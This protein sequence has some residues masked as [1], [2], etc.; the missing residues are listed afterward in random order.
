ME[1][2]AVRGHAR[3]AVDDV[4]EANPCDRRSSVQVGEV[5]RGGLT[6]GRDD[7]GAGARHLRLLG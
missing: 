3:L 2:D 4:E 6:A 7:R 5:A 1:F